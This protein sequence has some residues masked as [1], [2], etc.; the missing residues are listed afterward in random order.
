MMEVRH[1][2]LLRKI[3]GTNEDFNVHKIVVVKYW[4]ESTY[5]DIKGEQRKEYLITK[6]GCEFLSHK[7]TVNK[8]NLFTDRYMDG[9]GEM[10]RQIKQQVK[11]DSYMIADPIERAKQWIEEEKLLNI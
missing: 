11:Q 3:E 9:F 1:D 5:I 4:I 7:T 10:E 8:E 2:S 6:R